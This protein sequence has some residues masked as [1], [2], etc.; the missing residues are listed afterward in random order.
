VVEACRRACLRGLGCQ[1]LP[2][3]RVTGVWRIA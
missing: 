1:V 2:S 3:A